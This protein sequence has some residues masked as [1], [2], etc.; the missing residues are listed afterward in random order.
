MRKLILIMAICLMPAAAFAQET[1]FGDGDVTIGGFGGPVIGVTSLNGE[2]GLM[3]GGRG[4]VVINKSIAIGG[5][6]WGLS[7]MNIKEQIDFLDERRDVYLTMGYGGLNFEYIHNADKAYHFSTMLHVGW[8][9]VQYHDEFEFGDDVEDDYDRY[10]SDSFFVL[11]PSVNFEVNMF[12][13]MKVGIGGSYRFV[14]G[15]DNYHGLEDSD[16]SGLSGALT[17]KFGGNF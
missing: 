4:A 10:G 2:P 9:A 16:L 3:I 17:F 14:S 7:T 5:G 1:L 13:W 11:E 6:G 12:K 8:G 15:V